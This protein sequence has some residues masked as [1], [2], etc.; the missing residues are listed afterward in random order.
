MRFRRSGNPDPEMV[1]QMLQCSSP[2]V[3]T[4]AYW[5]YSLPRLAHLVAEHCPQSTVSSDWDNVTLWPEASMEQCPQISAVICVVS[6]RSGD[7][8][9]QSTLESDVLVVGGKDLAEQRILPL[10]WGLPIPASS[11]PP[12]LGLPCQS[13]ACSLLSGQPW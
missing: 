9:S 13:L 11:L 6:S 8:K 10:G 3:P 2:G 1:S 4:A 5:E 7:L 12:A